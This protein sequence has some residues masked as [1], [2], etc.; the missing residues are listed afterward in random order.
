MA[1]SV[2]LDIH[3]CG[4]RVLEVTGRGSK[5]RVTRYEERA[6]APMGG[7]PDPEEL[8]EV[9]SEVFKGRRFSRNCVIAA[10]DA[11]DTVVREIPVPFK[12]DDQIRKVI[13]YEAEHHLHNCDAYDVVVQYARIGES[14]E[15][16]KL[17]VFAARKEDIARK[18]TACRAAGVEPLAMDLDALAMFNAVRASGV[19]EG[20]ASCA[21]LHI[22]NRSTE[23]VFAAEGRLHALR[24]VRM[25]VDSIAQGLARD[26]DI[27]VAEAGTKLTDLAEDE[28]QGD[29]L[30]P[31]DP[32]SE[33]KETEKSHAELERD[34]FH[35]KRNEFLARLKREYVRFAATASPMST[36][37]RV[38]VSGPGLLVPG[39]LDLLGAKLG[40]SL[41][42]F[43][44][45]QVCPCKLGDT[46][47]EQFDAGS[48]VAL[49]LALKGLHND[50]LGL[51][52]RQED[53]K[54]ANKFE[55]LKVPLA[56][57]VTLL[58]FSLLVF[59]LF[60]VT[61]KNRIQ[62]KRFDPMLN[63]AYQAYAEVA[64]KFNDLGEMLVPRR[65]QV[66]P[67]RVERS[68]PRYLAIHRFVGSLKTMRR[69]LYKKV[70]NDKGLTPINSALKIWNDIFH[71][72]RENHEKLG[73]ID[74][75]T[76]DIRQERITLTMIVESATAMEFLKERLK[77]LD[78]LAGLD[79]EPPGVDPVGKY[80][81]TRFAFQ[82]R[83]RRRGR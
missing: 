62:E 14:A 20:A 83:H 35:V 73:Y 49:G 10:V 22:G 76:I 23:M 48:P 59:S 34:L 5:F 68:G 7:A 39:L 55:L 57:T 46:A 1:K 78:S 33:K 63:K 67:N 28:E 75:E 50:P 21:M 12:S 19:I 8:R 61:K 24:S 17:I 43:Q 25:G 27:D 69:R 65:D 58:F 70:G 15:G 66:D 41:E 30:V 2:G 52:F 72:I 64:R 42:A 74:F 32:M 18:V 40:V 81:K 47:A 60:C 13:K 9:L 80:V 16:T 37:E 51:D 6:V 29:L 54:V 4:V 11:H 45:S 82:E 36:P 56:V 26:M 77:N 44:P 71:V 79:L 38:L 3:S 31:V 53:W